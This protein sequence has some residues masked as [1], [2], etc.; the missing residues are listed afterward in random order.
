MKLDDIYKLMYKKIFK[1]LF[2]L[3]FF[4]NL[5]NCNL[6]M[7]SN[8]LLL[9]G[10][11]H[12]TSFKFNVHIIYIFK[13][14][15]AFLIKFLHADLWFSRRM[16]TPQCLKRETSAYMQLDITHELFH[17]GSPSHI[18]TSPL[19]FGANQWTGFYMIEIS[20]MKALIHTIYKL[21]DMAS[22]GNLH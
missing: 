17:E 21:I 3:T 8:I 1:L 22:V 10:S 11:V 20:T 4:Y 7:E 14:D 5:E 12:S 6:S 13:I 16:F 19:I 9:Q 2:L 18:E 15:W